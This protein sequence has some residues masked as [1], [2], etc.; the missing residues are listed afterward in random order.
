MSCRL[1]CNAMPYQHIPQ[2]AFEA[3]YFHSSFAEVAD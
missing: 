1:V 3:P 2:R